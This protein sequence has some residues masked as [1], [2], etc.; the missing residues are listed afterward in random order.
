ME[1]KRLLQ[2]P[3]AIEGLRFEDAHRHQEIL[4]ALNDVFFHWGYLPVETPVF[5]FF[6]IYRPLLHGRDLEKIYRLIDR[7]GDL[8][9]L[10]SDITLFLAKQLG[11]SLRK[12]NLPVRACYADVILRHQNQEDISSNEFFQVGAELIGKPGKD[13]DLEILFLTLKILETL[14]VSARIHIGSR[15]FYNAACQGLSPEEVKTLSGAVCSRERGDILNL[16]KK[17]QS[18]AVCRLTAD[19]LLFLGTTAEYRDLFKACKARIPSEDMKRELQYLLDLGNILEEA[20]MASHIRID[21]S[22]IGSQPYYTGLVFQGYMEHLDSAFL[23]GGRY[24]GLLSTFGLS[25]PSVGFSFFPRKIEPWIGRPE[26]FFPSDGVEKA[27]GT[28]FLEKIRHAEE[29]RRNGKRVIL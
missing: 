1:R 3:G 17:T 26:R 2:F 29:L 18:P 24:D 11:L 27:R 22:E 28:T 7:E 9:M 16:L 5:D 25:A 15:A 21:L 6:D 19:L 23:G 8:L 10:R 4:L 13:G 14:E 12:D 20:G